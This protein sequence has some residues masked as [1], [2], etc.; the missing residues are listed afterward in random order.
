MPRCTEPAARRTRLL[1]ATAAILLAWQAA[2]VAEEAGIPTAAPVPGATEPAL[3]ATD[4]A[5][6]VAEAAQPVTEAG[7]ESVLPASRGSLPDLAIPLLAHDLDLHGS[8][9]EAVVPFNLA[10][11]EEFTGATLALSY[12]NALAVLPD[13]SRL[14]LTLNGKP[15]TDLPLV[16]AQGAAGAEIGL[17]PGLFRTGRNELGVTLAQTHRLACSR[18]RFGELWTKLK[19]NGTSLALHRP[20]PRAAVTGDGLVGLLSA[21]AYDQEPLA[22]ATAA[23]L[24]GPAGV[25]LGA[26]V[27]QAVALVRGDRPLPVAALP[28]ESLEWPALHGRNHVLL[29]QIDEFRDL[30]DPASLAELAAE[31]MLVRRLPGDPDHLAILFAGED[32]AAVGRAVEGFVAGAARPLDPPPLP[33]IDG[34]AVLT[35]AELGFRTR[36]LPLGVT[37][38]LDLTFR[39]PAS[40]YAADGQRLELALNYAYAGGLQPTSALVIEV[41]GISANMIRLDDPRGRIVDGARVGLTLGMFHPGVNRISIYPMLDPAS[42]KACDSTAPMLSLFQDSRITMPD[43]A[44]LT[45]GGQLYDLVDDAFPYG[46]E[47]A[48]VMVSARDPAAL[49]AAWTFLGKL[50]QRRGEVLDRLSFVPPGSMPIEHLI[51]VG[52][53][54]E[55]SPSLV[56]RLDLPWTETAEPPAVPVAA[57]AATTPVAASVPDPRAEWQSRIGPEAGEGLLE[58]LRRLIVSAADA[59]VATPMPQRPPRP[60]AP[61]T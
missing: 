24:A 31:R 26:R 54:D 48:A 34:G 12:S 27:A 2:A 56:A 18:E 15:L 51:A 55:L 1:A 28:F 7:M 40:F 33:E 49:G 16:G 11:G 17:P 57:G 44:R 21:S 38:P 35:L 61:G 30:L 42:A 9:N 29:G 53:A 20:G 23:S 4:A 59:D 43:F 52:T 6:P 46:E 36:E 39:L 60:V 37:E 47:P 14:A 50:A 10:P 8:R 58:R 13:R 32:T 25:E 5:Q 19:R 45:H 41:N 22:I 3:A